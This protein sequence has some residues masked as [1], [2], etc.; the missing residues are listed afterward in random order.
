MRLPMTANAVLFFSWVV[1]CLLALWIC[2][3]VLRGWCL[4]QLLELPMHLWFGGWCESSKA[5]R[6][7][8][9]S[10]WLCI[11]A[12][13]ATSVEHSQLWR[14]QAVGKHWLAQRFLLIKYTGAVFLWRNC[15]WTQLRKMGDGCL[16]KIFSENHNLSL[17]NCCFF[18]WLLS[19]VKTA[20]VKLMFSFSSTVGNYTDRKRCQK[21]TATD[22]DFCYEWWELGV[23]S[24]W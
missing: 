1:M 22:K 5:G 6:G 13:I 3:V 2:A 4:A 7:L 16:V 10:W 9:G 11:W 12:G 19:L 15:V 18:K 20:F 17:I 14:L 24:Y 8:S 21:A 23:K